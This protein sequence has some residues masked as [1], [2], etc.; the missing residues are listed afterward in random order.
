ML[1]FWHMLFFNILNFMSD[2]SIFL[3][4]ILLIC[5]RIAQCVCDQHI[6]QSLFWHF[7]H[8][9]KIKNIIMNFVGLMLFFFSSW[10]R[11]LLLFIKSKIFIQ[12]SGVM[13]FS[14]F[15][16]TMSVTRIRFYSTFTQVLQGS[17][18]SLGSSSW[19]AKLKVVYDLIWYYFLKIS[20]KICQNKIY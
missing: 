5:G 9:A 4:L 8:D 2:F 18:S 3:S 16:H 10:C 14:F 1:C 17:K 6:R 11:F 15:V 13:K 12:A 7:S 20:I 19:L